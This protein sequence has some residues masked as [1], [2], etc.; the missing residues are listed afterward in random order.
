[1]EGTQNPYYNNEGGGD[2]GSAYNDPKNGYVNNDHD[3]DD[4]DEEGRRND[5]TR[6]HSQEDID[7]DDQTIAS[8]PRVLLM[9]PRRGGKTSIE[10]CSDACVCMCYGVFLVDRPLFFLFL[11]LRFVLLLLSLILI[12]IIIFFFFFT[13]G[14]LS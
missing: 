2:V 7:F 14:R 11:L 10:V 8:L 9:G 5:A 12:V 13:E 1:M 6:H 3:D 4:D